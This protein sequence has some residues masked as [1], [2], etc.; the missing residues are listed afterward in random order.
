MRRI[1]SQLARRSIRA[2][3]FS[4]AIGPVFPVVAAVYYEWTDDAGVVHLTD[5]L[6]E[7]PLRYRDRVRELP[8]PDQPPSRDD[9]PSAVPQPPSP[10]SAPTADVDFRG[11]D[12]QWWRQYL[13]DWRGRKATAEQSLAEARDRYNRLYSSH[14]SL[15]DVRRE[16]EQ[17]ETDLREADRMLNDVI[18]DEARKAGAPPGWLRE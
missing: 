7:L 8:V 14:Q 2:L 5:N 4:I 17:Y 10:P 15:G 1:D 6:A 3:V 11:H 9:Q 16:I 18:P 13:Q 12:R